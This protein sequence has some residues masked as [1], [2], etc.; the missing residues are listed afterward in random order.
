MDLSQIN[1]EEILKVYSDW[2]N[3]QTIR[4]K[5][6][7]QE[8]DCNQDVYVAAILKNKVSKVKV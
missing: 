2:K 8:A 4:R 6:S 1:D 7:D 3:Q 5:R